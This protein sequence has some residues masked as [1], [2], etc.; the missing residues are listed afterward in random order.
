[1]LMN[2]QTTF[3][4]QLLKSKNSQK[5]Q[6][7]IKY[8]K[9][10]RMKKLALLLF[11]VTSLCATG[12]NFN[13]NDEEPKMTPAM[14]EF[15]TPVPKVVT[16]GKTVSEDILVQP[17]SDAIVLFD[18]KDLSQWE[19]APARSTYYTPDENS[20]FN[21]NTGTEAKWDVSDGLLTVNKKEGDIQTKMSF[22]NFQLHIEWRVPEDI[23]GEG[24]WR[25]NSGIILQGV[26]EL[27]ILDS[28]QQETYTNGIAGSIYKQTAPLVNAMRKPGEW[29]T[30][31]IIYTAPTFMED[32]RFRT[33]P[34]VTVLLNGILVQSNTVILGPTKWIGVPQ[35]TLHGEG[36]IRLQ[37][38]AD[39]SE[40]DSF[41]NIWIREL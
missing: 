2:S 1:M 24:Q 17:S 30:Y 28:Y 26:Y 18:G 8:L 31:D 35:A 36:P 41:R 39:P 4:M 23:T 40:P 33:P 11:T 27:Q 38:H 10:K 16:P 6:H 9:I 15:Y 25:G 7:T 19:K 3:M 34:S 13:Q 20:E 5:K 29:N 21:F 32:G 22:E 37:A 12:Q 14:T